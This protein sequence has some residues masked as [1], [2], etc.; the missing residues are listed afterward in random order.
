MDVVNILNTLGTKF[1]KFE[2]SEPYKR[3]DKKHAETC[4]KNKL[5]RKKKSNKKK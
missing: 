3:N 5:K 2:I 1:P 4:K